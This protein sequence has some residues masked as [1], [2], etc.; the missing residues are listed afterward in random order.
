MKKLNTNSLNTKD[1]NIRKKIR[2]LTFLFTLLLITALSVEYYYE[3]GGEILS[4]SSTVNGR[5]LPIYCVKTDKPEIALTFDAA[6]ADC[7]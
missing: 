4:V 3:R 5:E 6:W 7:N 2:K 1:L